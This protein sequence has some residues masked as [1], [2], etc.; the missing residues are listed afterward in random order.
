MTLVEASKARYVVPMPKAAAASRAFAIDPF[1]P[2]R[3]EQRMLATFMKAADTFDA[4]HGKSKLTAR[5]QLEKEGIITKT[6]KL[7]RHYGG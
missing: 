6:G 4:K 3:S 7:T 1:D 2:I 5:K